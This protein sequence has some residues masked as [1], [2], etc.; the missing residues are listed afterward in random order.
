MSLHVLTHIKRMKLHE[1]KNEHLL[2]QLKLYFSK[3]MFVR[4]FGRVL[5]TATYLLNR[6]P[7]KILES[8]SPMKVYPLSTTPRLYKLTP[9]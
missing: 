7:S 2:P 1:E 4:N 8:K 9:T 3:I 6:F 5:P